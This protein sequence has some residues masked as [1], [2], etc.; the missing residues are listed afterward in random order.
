[1]DQD[2]YVVI[3][4]TLEEA[5]GFILKLQ[6]KNP[7]IFALIDQRARTI[8]IA[9]IPKAALP[10][11]MPAASACAGAHARPPPNME[12]ADIHPAHTFRPLADRFRDLE[13]VP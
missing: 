6:Q 8:T 9:E 11:P 2:G 10:D 5:R 13:A 4:A 3:E 1:V 12:A 7:R